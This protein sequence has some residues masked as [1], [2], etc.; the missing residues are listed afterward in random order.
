MHGKQPRI[1]SLCKAQLPDFQEVREVEY[2]ELNVKQSML[3]VQIPKALT[4]S[5]A[6]VQFR[7][8]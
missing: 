3:R 4:R 6:V 1:S 8:Q 7:T 2:A 5:T